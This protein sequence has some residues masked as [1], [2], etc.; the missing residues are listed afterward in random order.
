VQ[1]RIFIDRCYREFPVRDVSS[2]GI[3][4]EHLCWQF[5]PGQ[6]LGFDLLLGG[7]IVIRDLPVE[8]R[9]IDNQIAG[10][11]FRHLTPNQKVM[12]AAFL[13][14]V[15]SGGEDALTGQHGVNRPL[16]VRVDNLRAWIGKVNRAF[17]IRDISSDGFAFLRDDAPFK[18]GEHISLDFLDGERKLLQLVAAR[19]ERVDDEVVGCSFEK[20]S[21]DQAETLFSLISEQLG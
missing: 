18:P 10:C 20:L 5:Q 19:V 8:V 11:A 2:T 21:L 15:E 9:R 13:L 12:L 4:F 17:A 6:R 3:G 16:R 1:A 7:E 14:R